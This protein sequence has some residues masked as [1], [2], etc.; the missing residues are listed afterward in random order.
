M[1]LRTRLAFIGIALR[2]TDVGTP[3]IDSR[4]SK[5]GSSISLLN[6]LETSIN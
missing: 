2:M 3:D 4:I 6:H 1:T 5:D